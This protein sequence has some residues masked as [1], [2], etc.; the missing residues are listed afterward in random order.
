MLA[1]SRNEGRFAAF[2]ALLGYIESGEGLFD[3]DRLAFRETLVSLEKTIAADGTL[4][5]IKLHKRIAEDL[6]A[7]A[8]IERNYEKEL[9]QIFSRFEPR[10]MRRLRAAAFQCGAAQPGLGV[11]DAVWLHGF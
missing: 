2:D 6:D 7:L 1:A 5:A 4:P 9:K 8:E 11:R 10:A 3:T